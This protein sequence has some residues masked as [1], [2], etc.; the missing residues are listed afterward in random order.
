MQFSF[1]NQGLQWNDAW[2]LLEGAWRTLQMAVASALI[3]TVLGVILGWLRSV[4]V[5]LRVATAPYVDVLRSVPMLI[6]LILANSA[7]SMLGFPTS[8]F[9]FGVVA[10]S[11]W[12]SA[13]TAEVTRAA[14]DAV[15]TAYVRGAR[16]LGMTYRQ[17]LYHVS[18]P[19]AVRT[20]FAPWIG[21][22]LSLTKDSSLAGIIGY[23]EFAR[24]S[25]VLMNR[26]HETWLL[27][28]GMGLFY[29]VLCYPISR[30]S[31]AYE[32]RNF[33]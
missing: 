20:G 6:Q 11:L 30:F 29:F 19:I 28:F 1:A 18:L 2:F 16:S 9:W 4:S 17:Q 33:Q 8:T 21:L 26:T 15:P 22:V 5:V 3:G 32:R 27:L 31:R 10:L 23:M 24:T 12:M 25:Q 13:V 14:L 7:L